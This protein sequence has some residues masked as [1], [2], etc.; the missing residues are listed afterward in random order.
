M[1]Q[2]FGVDVSQVTLFLH[3]FEIVLTF[4]PTSFNESSFHFLGGYAMILVSNLALSSII[5]V[6]N[7]AFVQIKLKVHIITPTLLKPGTEIY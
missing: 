2:A 7:H 5:C 4:F 3:C 1:F 6:S